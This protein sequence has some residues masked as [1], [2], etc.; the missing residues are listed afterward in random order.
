M[1]N[2]LKYFFK[3]KNSFEPK[4][5]GEK[6]MPNLPNDFKI[7]K[8]LKA[9]NKS[10]ISMEGNDNIVVINMSLGFP[11]HCVET[12]REIFN[13]F[14]RLYKN[15]KTIIVAAGNFGPLPNTLSPFALS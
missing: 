8:L 3:P 1:I 9:I 7:G 2:I 11:P 10:L 6:V 13:T 5:I 15:G 14:E 4:H 12:N